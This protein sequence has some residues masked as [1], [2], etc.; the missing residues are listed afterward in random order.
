MSSE[1]S[2]SQLSVVFYAQD[3]EQAAEAAQEVISRQSTGDSQRQHN[4]SSVDSQQV[5]V[6]R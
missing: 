1:S 4:K 2:V 6:N 5:T 3:A